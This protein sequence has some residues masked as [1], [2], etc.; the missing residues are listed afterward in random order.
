LDNEKVKNTHAAVPIIN[1]NIGKE[2]V[3]LLHP[4]QPSTA[5]QNTP[6]P[7]SPPHT[8]PM[9]SRTSYDLQCPTLLQANRAPGVDM[10]IANFCDAYDLMDTVKDKLIENKYFFSRV[11]RFVTIKDL[12][13]MSFRSGEIAMLRDAVDRWSTV[14]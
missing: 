8:T 5:V 12:E 1:V 6:P 4:R 3:E 11:L 2:L 13:D 10:A 7:K 14:L 9:P